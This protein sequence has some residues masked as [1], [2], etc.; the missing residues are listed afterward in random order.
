MG[1]YRQ[2]EQKQYKSSTIETEE[3]KEETARREME[4]SQ[5]EQQIAF[6]VDRLD[7]VTFYDAVPELTFASD[8]S[9][10]SDGSKGRFVTD[11]PPRRLVSSERDSTG[12]LTSLNNGLPLT[13]TE[14]SNV[15]DNNEVT[16]NLS[17]ISSTAEETSVGTGSSRQRSISWGTVTTRKY[18]IIPGDHPDT[19]EG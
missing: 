16:N 15:E 13:R 9:S 5:Q 3:K 18:P 17:P 14:L 7:N 2:R 19:Y 1:V 8:C 10:N 4:G 12:S 11:A 6:L